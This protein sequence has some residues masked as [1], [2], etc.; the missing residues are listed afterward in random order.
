M[1]APWAS[2]KTAMMAAV[3]APK[4]TSGIEP[5]YVRSER[6]TTRLAKKLHTPI[7]APTAKRIHPR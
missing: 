2:V 5:S 3:A 1:M 7:S 4:V 6:A